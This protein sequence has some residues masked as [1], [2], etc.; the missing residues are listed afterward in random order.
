MDKAKEAAATSQGA[1]AA[2]AA[3][4]R[5]V[6]A[7]SSSIGDVNGERGELIY[8]GYNIHDLAAHSTFEETVFLLWHGRLPKQTELDELKQAS[9]PSYEVPPEVFVLMRQSPRE[10]EPM[11]TLRTTISALAFYDKHARDITRAGAL[12]T[13]TRLT[14]QFPVIVAALERLRRGQELI[15]P[16]PELNIAT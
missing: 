4:L 14:A 10:A 16:K 13:A 7:A 6:V 3:G 9:G 8:Q 2:S 15:A 12:R 5:G 1:T 11:D